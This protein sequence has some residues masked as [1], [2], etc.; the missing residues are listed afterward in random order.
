MSGLLAGFV[1]GLAKGGLD[2]INT[3]EAEQRKIQDEARREEAAMRAEERR[4]L[5]EQ[6]RQE[7]LEAL[8]VEREERTRKRDATDMIEADA[9]AQGAVK[10]RGF[11][12]FKS[13]L[14]QTDA[15]EA[16]LRQVYESQYHDK[17]VG[18]FQGADRY[19]VKESD[20]SQERLRQLQKRGASSGLISSAFN[21]LKSVQ[22]AERDA[23][24][25][26]FNERKLAQKEANDKETLAQRDRESERRLEAIVAR[27]GGGAGNVSRE[28]RIRYT[29][30]FNE[31]GRRLSEAQ[32]ARTTLMKEPGAA[33]RNAKE[34]SDL[35][36]EI[37][38]LKDERKLY[39][40]FLSQSQIESAKPAD[41]PAA[42]ADQ[43]R[44]SPSDPRRTDKGSYASVD[45]A[46]IPEMIRM[47][48]Q[49]LAE[50]VGRNDTAT[51]EGLQRDLESLK[52]R[53]IEA[54]SVNQN[55]GQS[56]SQKKGSVLS[57][58]PPGAKVIGTSN[59]KKVYEVNGKR[60][61]QQ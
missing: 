61:I 38:A 50:A 44:G 1:G 12:K 28:E 17:R 41:A 13:D 52:K 5:A 40:G 54:S 51:A 10:D 43:G 11:E 20:K 49:E 58:L 19:D 21:E 6:K 7:T 39:Q 59:G 34:L 14:G 60:Y 56:T 55:D 48:Q 9:A 47:R 22:G 46:S 33:R 53:Q 27:S 8:R 36:E 42:V 57:D 26:A 45:P 2:I 16:E 23:E 35:D 32:K 37:K 18:D 4:A 24:T 31:T 25:R 29:T 15:S 3:Q 30:L